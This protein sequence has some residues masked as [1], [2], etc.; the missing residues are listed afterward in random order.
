MPDTWSLVVPVKV[1][2]HAKSRLAGLA[3]PDR[4]RLALALAM[5]TVTAALGC[6]RV[7]RVV[8]VT[9]D[10]LAAPALAACGARVIPDAPD[11]GLN[12]ALRHGARV[13]AAEGAEKVGALSADLPAL[14]PDDLARTLSAADRWPRSFLADASG[15]G[16]TLYAAAADLFAPEFGERSRD[17]HARAGAVELPGAASVRRDVD[18]PHDLD[19]ALRLGVGEHTAEVVRSLRVVRERDH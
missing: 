11:A 19:E 3:G 12:P 16:T 7:R 4:E 10:P 13:A 9:D 6:P 18:T 5:D 15:A 1:L 8:V 17:R 2:R 14:R